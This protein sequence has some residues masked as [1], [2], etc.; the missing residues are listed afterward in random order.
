MAA[1]VAEIALMQPVM[2]T[3]FWKRDLDAPMRASPDQTRPI[4]GLPASYSARLWP[5]T[6]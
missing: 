5:G 1:F 2:L 3:P 4:L 6:L